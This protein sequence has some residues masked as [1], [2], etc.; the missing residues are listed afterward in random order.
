MNE[1]KIIIEGKPFSVN[2]QYIRKKGA[3]KYI[4]SN[5]A[6]SYG[7]QVGWQVKMQYRGRILTEDLEVSYYYYFNNHLRRDHLNF[8]KILND[9]F[10]QIVWQD[11]SQILASHHYTCFDKSNPRI[12][13]F[14][15]KYERKTS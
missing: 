4:L 8:Q 13:V 15:K 6:R 10:N 7:D 12:E 3:A 1:I 9:R 2:Q 11:D 5:E 14:I